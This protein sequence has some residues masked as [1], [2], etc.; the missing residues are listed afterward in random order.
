MNKL[1]EM[2]DHLG[3]QMEKLQALLIKEPILDEI[4]KTVDEYFE[5]K[6][7]FKERHVAQYTI[8]IM[9]QKIVELNKQVEQ[10][11]RQIK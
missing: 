11:K 4:K 8:G 6:T 7:D 1:N 2:A 3:E 5:T 10:L 9:S